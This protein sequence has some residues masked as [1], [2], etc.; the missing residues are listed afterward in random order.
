MTDSLLFK[1]LMENVTEAVYFKDLE[2]RFIAINR[3]LADKFGLDDPQDAVGKTD[4]D[5]FGL[6]HAQ[7]A[8]EDEQEI[9]TTKQPIL[10][11]VEKEDFKESEQ[12]L[13]SSTSKFP[14]FNETGEL[15]GT[16]G[17][18]RD[19]TIEKRYQERLKKSYDDFHKFSEQA[20]GLFYVFKQDPDGSTYLPF[21]S[22]AI[23]QIFELQPEDVDKSLKPIIS[24]IH[25][26]DL[27]R[28]IM[29]VYIAVTKLR[30]WNHEFR[31]VLPD[32]G[33]R[34]VRG[35]AKPEMQPDGSV[36]GY[37]YVT[38]ITHLKSANAENKRLRL[39]FQAI[40]DTVPN[41]IF[42]KDYNG[43]FTMVNKAAADFFGMTE[44]EMIGKNDVDLGETE[45]R[46]RVFIE[47][48]RRVID[49]GAI[50]FID[51]DPTLR[52]DGTEVW[53]QTIKV[54]FV[55][56]GTHKKAALSIVTDITLRKSKENELNETLDI[57]GDQN[58]RLKN[59]AHIVSHN[60]RNHA[61]N[62]SMLLS[63]YNTEETEEEKKDLMDY[64]N[65]A[66]ERLNE[67]INDLNEIIDQQYKE[68]DTLKDVNLGKTIE[69]IKE[70]LTTEILKEQVTFKEDI[71]ESLCF[72]YNPAYLESIILNM[73]SN[74]IKYRHPD[75]KPEIGI[76]AYCEEGHYY[77][78]ISDNGLGIDM[79]RHGDKLFGMYKT[80]HGNENSKGIGL[81]ITKNQVESMG[82]T[83]EVESEVNKGTTFKIKLK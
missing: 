58:K 68:A 65:Q 6:E 49:H 39:Q 60:L 34:W 23:N 77:L 83:I 36:V 16:Y 75:R 78:V 24:R 11:K 21:A 59:F 56:V 76:K 4:F 52:P 61:G 38:D 48:D 33:V 13:W 71:D 37:G 44:D 46:A 67:T 2:S 70:I 35:R 82:G 29:S 54:P 64:L 22:R 72:S 25:K 30:Q 57:I 80:F 10:N 55:Q 3:A 14:L 41:L 40:L 42:V 17:I 50:E 62:I 8:L 73:L 20:P 32:K 81:F 69:K 45:E 74:G 53:H 18:S 31:M 26:E 43:R 9:L 79:D 66:S 1:Q 5:F 51:E 15:I 63:L 28:T 47:R 19:I 12:E 27:R 7:L